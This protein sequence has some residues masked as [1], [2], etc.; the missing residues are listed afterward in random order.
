MTTRT[1]VSR[2]VLVLVDVFTRAAALSDDGAR[3]WLAWRWPD[4][5]RTWARHGAAILEHLE[6]NGHDHIVERLVGLLGDPRPGAR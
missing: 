3:A 6:H 1:P 2:R 5:D 4:P